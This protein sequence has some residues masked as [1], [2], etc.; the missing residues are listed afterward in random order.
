M[1]DTTIWYVHELDH[2]IFIREGAVT[3]RGAKKFKWFDGT[4]MRITYVGDL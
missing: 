3:Q 1:R 4:P 2:L